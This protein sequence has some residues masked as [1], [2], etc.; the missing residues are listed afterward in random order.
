MIGG[1]SCEDFAALEIRSREGDVQD[2]DAE[3]GV[4]GCIFKADGR[5]GTC[6]R[7]CGRVKPQL[8]RNRFT[9]CRWGVI[10]VDCEGGPYNTMKRTS[11]LD[12]QSCK[13][14]D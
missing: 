10:L 1:G 4:I 11:L 3:P 8:V 14:L 12:V 6:V 2:A 7:A 13:C 5:W 9:A